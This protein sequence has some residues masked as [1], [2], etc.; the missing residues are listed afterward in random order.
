[1]GT[2]KIKPRHLDEDF[3][4]PLN[5]LEEIPSVSDLAFT[6]LASS[7]EGEPPV[8]DPVVQR[9]IDDAVN[10]AVI[11]LKT[12][13]ARQ[14]INFANSLAELAESGDT[15]KVYVLP[16][17]YIYGYGQSN[18]S[19]TV[20]ETIAT[21]YSDGYRLSLTSGGTKASSSSTTTDFI[22]VRHTTSPLTFNLS[23]ITWGMEYEAETNNR[24]LCLYDDDKN[25]IEA[26]YTVV[27]GHNADHTWVTS[28]TLTNVTC[29]I[30]KDGFSGFAYIRFCGEGRGANATITMSYEQ[31][32]VGY[33][34]TRLMK[35]ID[36]VRTD[37]IGIVGE[38]NVIY[39]S[40]NNLPSG[41]YTLKY[42]DETYDTI[43][44]L[45]VE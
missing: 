21:T 23:G 25:L 4:L 37:L 38:N 34:W 18:I 12:Q 26:A 7:V 14:E 19:G 30:N 33:A 17:G 44:T 27:P 43:G 8:I 16:D 36:G 28:G 32:S 29:Q 1:M 22:D 11:D 2:S 42:G 3:K 40:D 35:V 41:N 9:A 20:T 13:I 39:L 45:T 15:S 10:E 5:K 6:A 24:G 31:E